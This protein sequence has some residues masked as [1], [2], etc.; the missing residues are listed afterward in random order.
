MTRD[1]WIL[2]LSAVGLALALIGGA[3]HAQAPKAETK[4][5]PAEKKAPA[6]KKA[7][8]P[9]QGLDEKAC[10]ANT[11]CSW[12]KATKTKAGVDRKAYCRLK[13]APPKKAAAPAKK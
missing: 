5:P 3:A 8:S 11:G 6:K 4:A 12:I 2:K 9:C 13:T 10:G 7:A 1:R